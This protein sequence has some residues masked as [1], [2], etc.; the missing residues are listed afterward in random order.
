ML[1]LN[2]KK[3]NPLKTKKM[4]SLKE[5]SQVNCEGSNIGFSFVLKSILYRVNNLENPSAFKIYTIGPH[6][7][8]SLK[9]TKGMLFYE[10]RPCGLESLWRK[11]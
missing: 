9:L 5:L 1:S 3:I 2:F 10:S 6:I 11:N 7:F 8:G 4:N